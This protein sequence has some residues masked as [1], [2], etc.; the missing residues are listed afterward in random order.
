MAD[1]SP[2]RNKA[3]AALSLALIGAVTLGA[4][5]AQAADW[6][7]VNQGQDRVMLIDVAS[8]KPGKGGRLAYWNT[9]VIADGAD[10]GVRMIKSYMLAD[11]AKARG[12]W[13]M[14]VRYDR[15]DRQ[16][17]VDSLGKPALATVEPGTL[18]EA[19]LKFVC[20]KA[21]DREG[22]GAFPVAVDARTFADALIVAGDEAPRAV[23]DRLAADPVTPIVRS[24][25][26]GPETFGRR[27]T[28]KT[29]QPLVPPR[30]Y[31][32][33]TGAPNA[34]DYPRDSSGDAYDVTFE[35]LEAGELKFEVRGYSAD[36]LIHPAMGQTE[37]FPADL[38]AIH[39]RDLAI[40]IDAVT[41]AAI[42]YRV[43]IEQEA[44][45]Q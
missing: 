10:D 9:Q 16:L 35:G 3:S 25:A 37:R 44:A 32:K 20:A 14:I 11:C 40:D 19:E 33:G 39:I 24:A 8:I 17:N 5:A 27:Q 29:G 31:A 36:D 28:A 34:A 45:A 1:A 22:A 30:D 13:G 6:W 15:D 18:G 12:G 2:F 42:T 7:Y 26:P 23:Y 21:G 41:D 4:G 43:R 38:K